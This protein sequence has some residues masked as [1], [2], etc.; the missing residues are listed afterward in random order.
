MYSLYNSHP[1][2]LVHTSKHSTIR[3]NTKLKYSLILTVPFLQLC[4]SI[5]EL[6]DRIGE[7]AYTIRPK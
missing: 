2:T 1:F 3:S 5:F 4:Y 6:F 7:R